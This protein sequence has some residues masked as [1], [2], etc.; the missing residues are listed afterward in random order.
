MV[1]EKEGKREEKEERMAFLSFLF[2]FVVV[3]TLVRLDRLRLF[4][5]LFSLPFSLFHTSTD[6]PLPLPVRHRRR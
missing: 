4:S 2:F 6:S 3:K 1:L 5:F